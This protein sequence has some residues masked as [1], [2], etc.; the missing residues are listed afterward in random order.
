M[1]Y[2]IY[3]VHYEVISAAARFTK[4]I[5]PGI[6]YWIYLLC[7]FALVGSVFVVVCGLY[8]VLLEK[9]VYGKGLA[10]AV[11]AIRKTTAGEKLRKF[12]RADV[13]AVRKVEHFWDYGG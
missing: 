4:S 6:P 9:L 13:Q 2:S 10:S 1:C 7:Q 3:L 11:T 5:A 12:D 8:F